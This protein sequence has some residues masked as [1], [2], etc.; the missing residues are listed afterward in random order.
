MV[1]ALTTAGGASAEARA[2]LVLDQ[3]PGVGLATLKK[4]VAVLGS[5]EAALRAPR[6]KF[7]EL[8]G[9]EA[10]RA[11]WDPAWAR[12]VDAGLAEAERLG[13]QV[14]TWSDPGYP[15]SLLH[16]HDPPPVLFLRGRA[17]L[18]GL[19]SVT[20]VGARRATV[21]AREVAERLGR[22]LARAGACV[23]SGMALGV[24]AAAHRGALA[25]DGA[26]VAVLGR[27]ADAPYPPGHR[28][29]FRKILERGLVV[30]EF[31]PGTPALPHHFPRRNRILAALPQAVVVVEAAARSGALITV[32]HALDV[33]VD[34]WAVPGPIDVAACA[35]SNRMLADGARPLVSVA[36]FVRELTGSETGGD[37]A[38]AR[39]EGPAGQ[40][41]ARLGDETLGVDELA[42]RAGLGVPAALA[43]LTDMELGGLVRQLPGMRFRRAA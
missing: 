24:D 3:L 43:L 17:E 5:A 35:G 33:G 41:L 7:R 40:L 32:D 16:L 21:R 4:L 8:A 20:V 29:L 34:V 23:V 18:L 13:M 1:D 25:G 6:S 42:E 37:R 26:T 36:D 31:L 39:V 14:T 28:R 30:S 11:R 27:G 10:E 38:R 19:P 2:L 15:P 9:G 22:D 12:L